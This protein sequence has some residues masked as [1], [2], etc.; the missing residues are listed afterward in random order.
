[1]PGGFLFLES[2]NKPYAVELV[3]DDDG[4]M[5]NKFLFGRE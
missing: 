5:K 2:R 1:M 3:G 4:K